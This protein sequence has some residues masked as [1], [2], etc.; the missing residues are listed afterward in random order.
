[1]CPHSFYIIYLWY[2][3]VF[4]KKVNYFS[5]PKLW[6]FP[7]FQD[8]AKLV[9]K[10]CFS[11]GEIKLRN[12]CYCLICSL[13]SF[14]GNKITAVIVF[15]I[16]MLSFNGKKE[17]PMIFNAWYGLV[18]WKICLKYFLS[19]VFCLDNALQITRE[20]LPWKLTVKICSFSF[21][22]L[23]VLIWRVLHVV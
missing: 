9:S 20:L 18:V 19:A 2:Y 3:H 13:F 10:D 14:V 1:M 11:R 6:C 12:F 17:I 8:G 5:D 22:P 7:V 4:L 16:K 21:S 23:S 15:F